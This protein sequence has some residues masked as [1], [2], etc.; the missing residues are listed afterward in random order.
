MTEFFGGRAGG[1][2]VMKRS[3]S[4]PGRVER[5]RARRIAWREGSVGMSGGRPQLRP[6]RPRACRLGK[7]G[8]AGL[9]SRPVSF[10]GPAGERNGRWAETLESAERRGE[11]H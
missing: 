9:K 5:E 3:Q 10:G 7:A 6:G 8:A 11:P 2:G 4:A 1:F